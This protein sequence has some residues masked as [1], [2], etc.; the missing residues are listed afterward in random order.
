MRLYLLIMFILSLSAI[1]LSHVPGVRAGDL[2][3]TLEAMK[4]EVAKMKNIAKT[5]VDLETHVTSWDHEIEDNMR[6]K[7]EQILKDEMEQILKTHVSPETRERLGKLKKKIKNIVKRV[8][9]LEASVAPGGR[10][11]R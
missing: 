2:K 8:G 10:G 9:E 11:G 1:V 4:I 6:E 3:E 7:I 5:L